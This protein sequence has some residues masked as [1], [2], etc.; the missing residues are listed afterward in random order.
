MDPVFIAPA[1]APDDLGRATQD[2]QDGAILS[3]V[4]P[5]A[6][7]LLASMGG[8]ALLATLLGLLALRSRAPRKDAAAD[9]TP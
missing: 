9:R 3:A 5:E 7:T 4:A 1:L 6:L 8:P 2:Q